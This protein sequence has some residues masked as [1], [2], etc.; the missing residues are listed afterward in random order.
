[1]RDPRVA[2]LLHELERTRFRDLAGARVSTT[3]P[4][5]ER[6]LN[7]ILTT[8]KP[9]DAPVQELSV[10]PLAGNRF[11]VRVKVGK[12]FVPPI[13]V[14]LDIVSQPVLPD[15]PVAEF[16]VNMP[17]GVMAFAGMAMSFLTSL[18]PGLRLEGERLFVDL[19]ELARRH[20]FSEYLGYAERVELSTEEGRLIVRADLKV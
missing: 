1:M 18:P 8:F 10:R 12:A 2:R 3:I 17:P 5:S 13:T 9:A 11:S 4:I 14:H 20:G 15:R 7:E 16:R 6:L 19:G